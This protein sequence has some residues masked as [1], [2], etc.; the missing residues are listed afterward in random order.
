MTDLGKVRAAELPS[1]VPWLNCE[2]PAEWT[3][4][5]KGQVIVLD[6]WTHCCINCLHMMP[7]L[8]RIEERFAL[9]P[10]QVVGVHTPKFLQE[11]DYESVA[12]AVHR[13]HIQH[14]VVMDSR[15]ELWSQF[16]VKAWPTIVLVDAEGYVREHISGETTVDDLSGRIEELLAEGNEK[17]CL[18]PD[19][20]DP[21]SDPT[22]D[23]HQLYYPG[24]VAADDRR[25]YIADS[26]HHRIVV[27]DHAGRV[28]KIIGDG[29]PGLRDGRHDHATF[30]DPQGMTRHH[31][32]LYV[33]DR[34]NH[35]LRRI[36]LDL[37]WVE[38]I[39]GNGELGTS[40]DDHDPERPLENALRSPWYVVAA[41]DHL[42]IAM[43]GSHQLWLYDIE[44]AEIGAWAGSGVEDHID[45]S[46]QEAAFA[47]PSGLCLAGNHLMVAD[48]E[49]SSVRAV[50]LEEGIVQTVVGQGLFDYGDVDG[51]GE[52]VLLQHCMDLA[53]IGEIL[54]VAD[55][56]NH[57]I[58]AIDLRTRR[59][60]NLFAEADSTALDEPAG[61]TAVGQRLLI[62]DTNHHRLLWG[63]PATGS[64]E[65]FDLDFPAELK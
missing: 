16:L 36:D 18:R 5:M 7:H 25:I 47:Q 23:H 34:G 33:A 13:Y 50:N 20:R 49:V 60:R 31:H 21:G 42:V 8:S 14:P 12:N 37:F 22:T 44:K 65:A 27:C 4:Q 39:A 38:T 40:G 64:L 19:F 59:C 62:A 61:I 58:K 29:S 3:A 63:D 48:S 54:Y 6:F 9:A 2:D 56:F 43:A 46:L 57:K 55:T 41:G 35:A 51:E 17:G 26:G 28:E 53:R 45:A 32:H 1:D 24:K 30:R 10:V 52:D 11:Q 15:Q